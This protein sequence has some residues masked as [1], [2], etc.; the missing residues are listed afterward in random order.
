MTAVTVALMGLTLAGAFIAVGVK[1]ILHAVF[2]LAISLAGVAG[3][4]VVL[5]SPLLAVMEVLIYV[6]GISVAMIFAVMMSRVIA[7]RKYEPTGRRVLA[8]LAAL[9]FFAG[10][11][12]VIARS[13]LAGIEVPADRDTRVATV[14]L[15]LL[16]QYNVVFEALSL[17]LLLAIIGAIT[18]ARRQIPETSDQKPETSDQRPEPSDQKPETSDQKPETQKPETSDQEGPS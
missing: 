10:M 17:V 11:A 6:G 1:S 14:G 7:V 3:L 9:V 13:D 4:F 16:N 15:Y 18:I 8:A 12:V 5:H 2:G